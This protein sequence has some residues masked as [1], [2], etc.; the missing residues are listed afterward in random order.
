[1]TFSLLSAYWGEA[2]VVPDSL[3]QAEYKYIDR[4][5]KFLFGQQSVKAES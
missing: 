4:S 3:L 5:K 2:V 1:M